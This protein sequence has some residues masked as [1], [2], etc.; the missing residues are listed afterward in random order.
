LQDFHQI[1]LS[2]EQAISKFHKEVNKDET[3]RV[4]PWDN[5]KRVVEFILAMSIPKSVQSFIGGQHCVMAPQI[6]PQQQRCPNN[7]N[8]G[9]PMHPMGR[10]LGPSLACCAHTCARH[11][12]ASGATRQVAM[13]IH[14]TPAA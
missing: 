13:T 11:S 12:T 4:S 8:S 1:A 10:I 3:V 9:V 14:L 2:D 5:G 6:T 7:S